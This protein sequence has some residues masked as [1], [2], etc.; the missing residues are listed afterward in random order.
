MSADQSTTEIQ[1]IELLRNLL[2][3]PAEL[4][5][6]TDMVSDLGLESV[7]IMEFVVT[8]EDHFDLMIDLD[9]LADVRTVSELAV[10]VDKL[11]LG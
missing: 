3:K 6:G 4:D 8:V 2:E 7:Q 10:I 9:T 1:I 5:P 11:A